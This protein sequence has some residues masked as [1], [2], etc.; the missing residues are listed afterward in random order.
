MGKQEQSNVNK[1]ECVG[2]AQT[3]HL[4]LHEPAGLEGR[5]VHLAGRRLQILV[6]KLVNIVSYSVICTTSITLTELTSTTSPL[7]GE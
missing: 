3:A 4:E 7:T 1:I 5:L 2:R 6:H